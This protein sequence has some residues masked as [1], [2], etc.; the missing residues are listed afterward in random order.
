MNEEPSN[1]DTIELLSILPKSDQI[2]EGDDTQYHGTGMSPAISK[3]DPE[4]GSLKGGESG[5]HSQSTRRRRL[6]KWPG[7]YDWEEISYLITVLLLAL[8]IVLLVA[9]APRISKELN[10]S[11]C[12]PNGEFTFPG[13]ASIWDS[14]L[15][16]AITITLGKNSSWSY[17]HVRVLD[18]VWDILVGRGGQAIILYIAYRVFHKS[19]MYIMDSQPVS[20]DTYGA[21]AFRTGTAGSMFAFLC[22]FFD[23]RFKRNRRSYRFYTAMTL[24]TAYILAMPTLFSVMTGYAAIATPSIEIPPTSNLAGEYQCAELGGCT[25]QICGGDGFQAGWGLC[26]D[27][28]RFNYVEPFVIPVDATGDSLAVKQY[29]ETYQ[30]EYDAAASDP[31]CSNFSALADCPPLAKASQITFADTFLSISHRRC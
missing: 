21:V 29:Y 23:D 16:F 13:T 5:I 4:G 25:T 3:Y 1:H 6:P 14:N 20:Y 26:S 10:S 18:I 17:V 19:I 22:A 30:T 27:S 12:L 2:R 15:F 11:A 7:F 8:P 9:C 24:S 28:L 31:R